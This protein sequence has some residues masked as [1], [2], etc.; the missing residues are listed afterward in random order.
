VNTIVLRHPSARSVA[1]AIVEHSILTQPTVPST[2][3]CRI[4][5]AAAGLI[6]TFEPDLDPYS[7]TN[8]IAW[9]SN[10]ASADGCAV[11]WFASRTAEERFRLWP[12]RSN[13]SGDTLLGESDRGR[14]ISV[15]LPETLVQLR[16]T[17]EPRHLMEPVVAGAVVEEFDVVSDSDPEFGNPDFRVSE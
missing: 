5:S 3:R 1:E 17:A 15:Y 11:G 16:S 7:F 13:I 8:L 14:R 6:I 10:G 9:L 12:D 4:R 2:H